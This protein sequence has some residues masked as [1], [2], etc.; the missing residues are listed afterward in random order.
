MVMK[1]KGS[2][3]G[4]VEK[5]QSTISVE[6]WLERE[7]YRRGMNGIGIRRSIVRT[8]IEVCVE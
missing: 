7:A 2:C 6:R 3:S 4:Y 1:K 5:S 8:T